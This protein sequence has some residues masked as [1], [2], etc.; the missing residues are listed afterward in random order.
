MTIRRRGR[1]LL[2]RLALQFHPLL[3][4]NR[5][6]S[7]VVAVTDRRYD[8]L[9]AR[10][11][12]RAWAFLVRS[13]V[14]I[15]RSGLTARRNQQRPDVLSPQGLREWVGEFKLAFRRL[16]KAPLFTAAAVALLAIGI[17]GNTAIFS[18]IRGA[19][20]SPP[21]YRDA[22]SLALLDLTD[23][24]TTRPGAPRPIPWSFPKYQLLAGL[25]LPLETSAVFAVRAFTLTGAGDATRLSGELVSEDYFAVLGIDPALGRT[26]GPTDHTAGATLTVVLEHGIWRDRYG[27]DRS[28]IGSIMNLNGHAVTIIGVAPPGFRGISGTARMWIPV[29]SAATLI[30]PE[31]VAGAQ[32]HWLRSVGRLIPEADLAVLN[33]RMAEAGRVIEETYPTSDPTVVRSASA[34]PLADAMVNDQARQSLL[35]LGSAT[36]L[37]LLGTC[38]NLAGLLRARA[39]DRTRDSAV[40][41]A[42]GAGRWRLARSWL[43][44][45]LLLAVLGGAASVIVAALGLK[46]L[47][48]IWPDRFFFSSW[49]VKAAGIDVAGIGATGLIFVGLATVA[50]G[51][52]LGAIPAVAATR[53]LNTDALRGGNVAPGGHPRWGGSRSFL[54]V[55]QIALAVV[56]LVGAGLLLRSLAELERVDRGFRPG[57]LVAFDLAIHGGAG[58]DGDRG[59]RLAENVL[60]QLANLPGVESAALACVPPLGGHCL[61]TG[62]GSAGTQQWPQE[63]QPRV[64]VQYVSDDYFMTLGVPLLR[65]RS[66]NT[67]DHFGPPV[68]ILSE[69]AARWLFPDGN[70][71]GRPV[72]LGIDLV[73]AKQPAPA[74]ERTGTASSATA[75]VIGVV[76]DVLY[77]RPDQGTMPDVYLS[78][79]QQGG[80]TTVIM[81][82]LGDELRPLREARALIGRI[83]PEVPLYNVRTI[84]QLERESTAET[85]VL[86][87]LLS[88]FAAMTA[89]LACTGVWAIVATAVAQRTREFGL[90]MALGAAPSTILTVVVRH[91]MALALSGLLLGGGAAWGLSRLIRGILYGVSPSDAVTYLAAGLG[92]LLVSFLATVVPASRTIRV[93][94]MAALRTE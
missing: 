16:L 27:G 47:A 93:Q 8:S 89:A 85:S 80:A 92:L 1:Q 81:R 49:N 9:R 51:L 18:A 44:E 2:V 30:A 10:S 35:I 23:S 20:L 87:I 48:T 15:A 75:E 43:A 17:G 91:G 59:T 72:A 79:G 19:L 86:A 32:A 11:R 88:V 82:T 90:R 46:G 77:S 53:A 94:P 41:L 25:D 76:G 4:R 63:S 29:E 52:L 36:L 61:I 6:G 50:T 71:L 57:N 56:L 24:S 21:P 83:A 60:A 70:A 84:E 13:L 22:G 34:Q 54:V 66:F 68:V 78:N 26:T 28:A 45:A 12:F 39:A 3:S 37:L 5:Y 67:A 7:E 65:G 58:I 69:S 62:V 38:A 42:L 74:V 33:S 14:D 64:G 73:P 31:L 40:R 55:G